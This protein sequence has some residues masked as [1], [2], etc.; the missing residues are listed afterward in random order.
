MTHGLPGVALA[1]EPSEPDVLRRPPRPRGEGILSGG[2]WQHILFDGLLL[3]VICLALGTW[4][5]ATG[6][7][8][9][10]MVFTVLALLQLGNALALR[11]DRESVFRL[12]WR[13]NPFLLA[14]LAGTLLLQLALI[15]LPAA[16]EILSTEPLSPA[17]LAVVLVVSTALFWVV[18]LQKLVRRRRQPVTEGPYNS[19]G[20]PIERINEPS[21]SVTDAGPPPLSQG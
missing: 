21:G 17:D 3:G 5:F 4:A 7:P 1:A 9:Q 20:E 18:E 13:H 10:T 16:Q 6:R 19:T 11:S 8:W 15:Y 14:V 12:G 2:L